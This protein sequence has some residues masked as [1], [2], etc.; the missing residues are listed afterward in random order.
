MNHPN[1]VITSLKPVYLDG[2]G[3][4]GPGIADWSQARAV[5]NGSAAFD[6]DAD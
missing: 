3:V 4:F 6:L 2:I 5:L 1:D